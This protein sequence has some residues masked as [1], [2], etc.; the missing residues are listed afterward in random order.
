LLPFKDENS[1]STVL[2]VFDSIIESL[3]ELSAIV[4]QTDL[5][6]VSELE[7]LELNITKLGL[8]YVQG[9]RLPQ[10]V[11]GR[12]KPMRSF[13]RRLWRLFPLITISCL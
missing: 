9:E 13:K 8:Y 6:N 3:T 5:Q 4:E 7:I 12:Y 11:R 1:F 10:G 2:E